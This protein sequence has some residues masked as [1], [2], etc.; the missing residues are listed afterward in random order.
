VECISGVD[1]G[2][3]NINNASTNSGVGGFAIIFNVNG[4]AYNSRGP[5]SSG[6]QFNGQISGINPGSQRQGVFTMIHELAHLLNVPGFRSDGK[7]QD[8]VRRNNDDV[9]QNCQQTIKATRN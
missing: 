7:S 2:D 1:A 5:R 6:I 9:W 8:N 4:S 3:D